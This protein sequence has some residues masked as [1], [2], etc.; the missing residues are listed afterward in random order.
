M[1]EKLI[2]FKKSYDFAKWMFD[3]TNKFPK[4]HCFSL[5]VRIENLIVELLTKYAN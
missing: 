3:H 5:A 4:S 2:I 1:S